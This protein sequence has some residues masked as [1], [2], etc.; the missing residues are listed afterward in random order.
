MNGR[1]SKP[2]RLGNR[3]T[4]L[5]CSETESRLARLHSV[6]PLR[7]GTLSM[8]LNEAS[9]KSASLDTSDSAEVV[10]L[11]VRDVSSPRPRRRVALIGGFQ[12]RKC[13]IATFTTDIYEQL[14][15]YHP[16][17]AVDLHVVDGAN[18]SHD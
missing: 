8:T 16:T 11:F 2:S 18:D 14:G 5:Q 17:F 13:G 10:E 6:T 15:A 9:A 12:P 1:A 7:D 4:M 3:P